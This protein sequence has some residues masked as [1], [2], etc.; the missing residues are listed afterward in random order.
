MQRKLV[1]ILAADVA[2]YTR[3]MS[4]DDGRT[5]KALDTGR[6]VFGGAIHGNGGRV[7][8]MAGD[9]IL[10]V[11]ETAT[12][13]VS[14]ALAAQKNLAVPQDISSDALTLRFRVGV[15]LGEVIVKAD[16]TVYGDGVNLAARLESLAVPGGICISVAVADQ[17]MG[18]IDE[19]FDDIGVH[20]VKNVERPIHALAW[21]VDGAAQPLVRRRNK[22]SVTIGAF[23]G[24]NESA[25]NLALGIKEAILAALSNQTGIEIGRDA[26]SADYVLE[27][28]FQVAGDRYR[29]NVHISDRK[30]DRHFAGQGYDG[31]IEDM[32]A[33]QDDL[34]YRIYN[35]FR[36]A[37]VDKEEEKSRGPEQSSVDS[38]ALINRAGYLTMTPDRKN[39]FE[40]Q[41]L[42]D[43]VLAS[44]PDNF[45]ALAIKTH[46]H[47]V[48]IF[49]GY[50]KIS[51]R[52]AEAGRE[53]AAR[54]LHL[55]PTSDYSNFTAAS[56]ALFF[57]HDHD[58]G[59][60]LLKRTL[61]LNPLY[62][63][64]TMG[65]GGAYVL[66][67]RLD[68]GIEHCT[69]VAE[70]DARL[71]I[72]F[73]SMQFLAMAEIA[74]GDHRAGLAWAQRADLRTPDAARTLVLITAA[75]AHAGERATMTDTGSRLLAT[76]PDFR[77]Q[78]F[79]NWPWRDPDL[80]N[81]LVEGLRIAG[82]PD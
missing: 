33:A 69:K 21:N 63:F 71:P 44:E 15:H 82:L 46:T 1:A 39:Y 32:F 60:A 5:L 51:R 6:A 2:G 78:D 37:I 48:E 61:D 47:C 52:D 24:D 8:D 79:G 56:A 3:L 72:G 64:G 81:R 50:R 55:N 30:E 75:A 35:A 20:A 40:A 54:A 49:A 12:E 43:S 67:G 57:D 22:P 17:I 29:A 53:T 41:A 66:A 77:L 45:M 7:V 25:K 80:G 28:R 62:A 18:K 27:G 19:V 13:A 10:A 14:A 42:L 34:A 70:S 68:D 73:W 11:F 31:N 65:L 9:S 23:E 4:L 16:G 36:L 59:I 74:R 38:E 76:H 26:A 58:A